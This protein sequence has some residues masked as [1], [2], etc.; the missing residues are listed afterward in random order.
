MS[1]FRLGILACDSG[2]GHTSR[3]AVIGRALADLGAEVTIFCPA[4][5]LSWARQIGGEKIYIEA[6]ETKD[7][8]QALRRGAAPASEW[9]DRLPSPDAFDVFISDNLPDVL[10]RYSDALLLGHFFWHEAIENMDRDY[11]RKM[12]TKL[13]RRRPNMVGSEL[14]V[15]PYLDQQT[16]LHTVGVITPRRHQVLFEGRD[17]LISCGTAGPAMEI[18]RSL[19]AE[20]VALGKVPFDVVHIDQPLIPANAPDWMVPADFSSDMYSRLQVAICRPGLGTVS[21]ALSA[22]TRI[23]SLYESGNAELVFNGETLV[24][25]GIGDNWSDDGSAAWAAA[26]QYAEDSV[27]QSNHRANALA[28]SFTGAD[29]AAKIILELGGAG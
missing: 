20:V 24:R 16:N 11:V 23:F 29:E 28:L 18:G 21:E 6:L 9:I 27:A 13:K 14:F 3:S 1:A 22:G 5:A 17:A 19:V 26:M 12:R 15:A 10:E 7:V 2:L 8:I 4:S 25:A